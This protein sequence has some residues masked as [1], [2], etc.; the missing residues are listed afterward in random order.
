[1]QMDR[2]TTKSQEAVRAAVDRAI[3]N[4]NPELVPEH[5]LVAIL[6]QRD[7]V[8]TPLIERAG[9]APGAVRRDLE[10]KIDGLPKVSGG[11]QPGLGRRVNALFQ[12]A[13]DE[14]KA[15]KDDF[16][17]VEHFIL[18]AAK[19]DKDVQ[20]IFDRYGLSHEKLLAALT[21]IR[22]AHRVTD[23][24][25]EGKFQALEKYTRDLTEL[26]R[27]AKI[28]PVIGRDEEIRRV[29]QVLSRRTKNN[30]VL[31][32]EPGVGKTAIAEGI[33]ARR[34]S[35]RVDASVALDLRS[36]PDPVPRWSKIA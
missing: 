27:R 31:I 35:S 13:E 16:I 7:G 26:A 30:P 10:Q 21:Q 15:H 28:D 20:A 3:R 2:L 6:E 5:V 29:M 14:A 12:K 34:R 22:G 25:P 19:A 4:G 33:A 9:A 1:M 23:Q 18:A 8:G 24:E 36:L 32:G 17:S 11:S